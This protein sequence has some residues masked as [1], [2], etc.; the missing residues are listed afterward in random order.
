MTK[1]QLVARVAAKTGLNKR[2]SAAVVTWLL[3]CIV[4]ALQAGDKVELRGFGSFRC[5]FRAP[6]RGRNPRTAETVDVPAK[7]VPSFKTGKA[8][9]ERLN[10]ELMQAPKLARR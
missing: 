2:E 7:R 9:H 5:R 1:A 8:I 4:E 10:P 3:R 6:R